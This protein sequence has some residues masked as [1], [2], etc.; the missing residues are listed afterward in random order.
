MYLGPIFLT[1]YIEIMEM[2]KEF[3]RL[4][5]A[6]VEKFEIDPNEPFDGMHNINK[7]KLKPKKEHEEEP[8]SHEFVWEKYAIGA[9][10]IFPHRPLGNVAVLT[11]KPTHKLGVMSQAYAWQAADAVLIFALVTLIE[12][13]TGFLPLW[14]F[15]TCRS[16]KKK[17]N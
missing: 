1:L 6:R 15:I 13:W 4:T 10:E 3:E 8:V 17:G 12:Q 2:S 11:L 14:K 7:K 16:K 9:M 5:G